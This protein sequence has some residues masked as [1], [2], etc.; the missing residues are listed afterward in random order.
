MCFIAHRDFKEV[1][2]P[3]DPRRIMVVGEMVAVVQQVSRYCLTHAAD[4]LPFYGLPDETE[5]ALFDPHVV[6]LC[7]PLADRFLAEIARPYLLWA[8]QAI[9]GKPTISTPMALVAQLQAVLN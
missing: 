4:V 3:A 1:P 5:I 2:A 8:E 6:V 7:L 9:P